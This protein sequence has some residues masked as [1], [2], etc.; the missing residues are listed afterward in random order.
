MSFLR[1]IL[2]GTYLAGVLGL[3]LGVVTRLIVPVAGLAPRGALVFSA[4]CFLCTLATREVATTLEKL[5][6]QSKARSATP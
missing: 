2:L 6:E 5:Q 1:I 3:A 4:A